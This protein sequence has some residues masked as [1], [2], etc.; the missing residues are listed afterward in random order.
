MEA[1]KNL[2]D[3][4]EK[5]WEKDVTEADAAKHKELKKTKSEACENYQTMDGKEM[6][7]RK[8]ECED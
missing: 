6:L 7:K 2:N 4:T 3:F 5:L 8:K 1:G